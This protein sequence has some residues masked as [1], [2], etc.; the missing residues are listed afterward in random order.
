MIYNSLF[1]K[2]K[3]NKKVRRNKK[4]LS[5]KIFSERKLDQLEYFILTSAFCIR[6]L[7]N[8]NKLSDFCDNYLFNVNQ[9]NCI[10]KP[11]FFNKDKLDF[12][13]D[14]NNVMETTINIKNL[15]N[16]LIHSY[17]LGFSFNENDVVDGFFVNS[18]YFK[19]KTIIKVLLKDWIKFIGTVIYD[20]IVY[21]IFTRDEKNE[22]KI[23]F[24][25][26]KI[27]NNVKRT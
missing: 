14:I 6:K 17:C 12:L 20:D 3:L 2:E 27:K 23:I 26:R 4:F 1:W 16:W 8:S 19:D 7:I 11:D 15:C 9:Y 25:K 21:A 10:S 24:K 18:D 22:M 13:Y 5:K